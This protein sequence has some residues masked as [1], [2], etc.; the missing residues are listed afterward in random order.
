M[1]F[2]MGE[3][4]EREA[5]TQELRKLVETFAQ[6]PEHL[7]FKPGTTIIV[8]PNGAGKTTLAKAVLYSIIMEQRIAQEQ[9][10][11]RPFTRADAEKEIFEP[12]GMASLFFG[13]RV[14]S[15]GPIVGHI[16]QALHTEKYNN[17]SDGTPQYWDLAQEAGVTAM[18]HNH[19]TSSLLEE[20]EGGY[21][22]NFKGEMKR[23]R[24]TGSKAIHVARN[25]N[26]QTL[27]RGMMLKIRYMKEQA[28]GKPQ[29]GF[30]DEP[31]AG[32]D[33]RRHMGLLAEVDDFSG[34]ESI[35]IVVTNSPVLFADPNVARIDLA[36]PERGIFYPR[37]YPEDKN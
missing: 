2:P 34:P 33:P 21:T 10:S 17:I 12:K 14:K 26:R 7:E 5:K 20:S 29:V 25:S 27:D 22:S 13:N 4:G 6:L 35:R 15:D 28:E 16:A 36:F 31:E 3:E 23:T 18:L 11:G 19:R 30:F 32:M 1:H 37:D 9:D 24:G 8:G